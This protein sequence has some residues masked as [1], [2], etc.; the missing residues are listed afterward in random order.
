LAEYDLVFCDTCVG[1][2]TVAARLAGRAKGIRAFYLADYAVNP[3]GVRSR[4][5]VRGALLRWIEF[6]AAR[7]DLLVIACNTASVRLAECPE[8]LARAEELGLRV[9]SMRDLLEQ[10]LLASPG[11]VEGKRVCLMGTRFTVSESPYRERLWEAGATEVVPLAATVTERTV[12]HLQHLSPA[13]K[14]AI[15][16]EIGNTIRGSDTVV[17]ACTCFPL[18]REQIHELN[19]RCGLLDPAQGVTV[20]P[21]LGSGS[22]PNRL[23][24]AATGAGLS[25]QE[26][27]NQAPV[28]FVGWE[29]E[30]IRTLPPETV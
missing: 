6:A 16:A 4:E 21:P 28:L 22:G 27:R 1:G 23:S 12:A 7:S 5:E 11:R 14:K 29:L 9:Y 24:V 8:A 3:L 17:L 19:P 15:G 13:G 10:A 25:D 30:E 18:V 26:L 20:L 2:S